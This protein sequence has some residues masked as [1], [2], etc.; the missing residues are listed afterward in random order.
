MLATATA[1]IA[2]HV[3]ARATRDAYFLTNFPYTTLPAMVM[4]TSILAVTLAF[5]STR[6]FRRWA[7]ERIVPAA[8]VVSAGLLM[9]EW[10]VSLVSPRLAGCSSITLRC[11]ARLV[12]ASIR[13]DR[14]RPALGEAA[15]GRITGRTVGG[16]LGGLA[17]RRS[18]V[19]P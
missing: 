16:L 18:N 17:A 12:S 13:I 4:A 3:G 7:P 19:P 10:G 9:V 11:F 6:A 15:V 2:F 5:A 8:F 1:M 14:I